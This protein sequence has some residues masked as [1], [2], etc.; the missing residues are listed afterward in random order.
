MSR[1]PRKDP[2]PTDHNA[3]GGTLPG[4]RMMLENGRANG[5]RWRV[6]AG[7][8]VQAALLALVLSLPLF[9]TEPLGA[10]APGHEPPVYLAPP[11]RGTPDGTGHGPGGG[12]PQPAPPRRPVSNMPNTPVFPVPGTQVVDVGPAPDVGPGNGS[13]PP[14]PGIPDGSGIGIPGGEGPGGGAPPPVVIVQ[15]GKVRPPRLI[16]RVEPIY[17]PLARQAGIEGDV[18]L[19]ALLGTD[20]RVEQVRVVG[21]RPL[22][23]TSAQAAVEQWRYEPTHLN[24]RP[25][26]V[27]LR[28]TVQFRLRR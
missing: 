24:G 8:L 19:E 9:H 1:N 12:P 16:E 5:R 2:S 11:P 22:L 10:Q 23:A 14:G 7:F 21:G 27:L 4:L 13:G 26:A 28:V 25:V 3:A 17:P 18:L 15:G 20:G 6:S